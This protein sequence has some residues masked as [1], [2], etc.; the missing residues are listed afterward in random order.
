MADVLHI[1]EAENKPFLIVSIGRT[2]VS[3]NYMSLH[4]TADITS[5]YVTGIMEV[6]NS[7]G[8]GDFENFI[9]GQDVDLYFSGGEDYSE[10]YNLPMSI[11]EIL[12]P[13]SKGLRTPLGNVILK[14]KSKWAYQS[15]SLSTKAYIDITDPMDVIKGELKDVGM[16]EML[17]IS[18]P[19]EHFSKPQNIYRHSFLEALEERILPYVHVEG[20]GPAFLYQKI[21]GGMDIQSFHHMIQQPLRAHLFPAFNEAPLPNDNIPLL[22]FSK[23]GYFSNS[24]IPI[25]KVQ[26]Y[27]NDKGNL[28]H[29][30]R[31]KP[32]ERTGVVPELEKMLGE[33]D[34][35]IWYVGY[36]ATEQMQGH[37]DYIRRLQVFHQ[38][39]TLY[40]EDM[41]A[42]T[43]CDVGSK[44]YLHDY[45]QVLKNPEDEPDKDELTKSNM[46]GEYI[47]TTSH[48]FWNG[49]NTE[50]F[51]GTKLEL[52][53]VSYPSFSEVEEEANYIH[54]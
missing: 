27:Y 6:A 4:L 16:G 44:V 43:L 20:G 54:S 29:F 36:R 8:L 19:L 9:K 3:T 10:V 11:Y 12:L 46:D 49:L 34:T 28:K 37:A 31:S 13:V 17:Q 15:E 25:S 23:R 47:I 24:S 21:G 22:T 39:H 52:G 26:G 30:E 53:K 41:S 33:N 35:D 40:L 48:F 42:C 18:E 45:D 7:G 2:E 32:I 5:P 50:E 51:R 14:L 38:V 1:N